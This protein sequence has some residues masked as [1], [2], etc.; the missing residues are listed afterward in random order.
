MNPS[1]LK[2]LAQQ[3]RA[4][5]ASAVTV[6]LLPAAPTVEVT[7]A[8]RRA[9]RQ[10]N[11]GPGRGNRVIFSL[12]DPNGRA[13]RITAPHGPGGDGRRLFTWEKICQVS[14]WAVDK[15]TAAAVADEELQIQALEDLFEWVVRAVHARAP[16]VVDWGDVAIRAATERQFGLELVCTFVF[17]GPL[18]D[19]EPVL[20]TPVGLNPINKVLT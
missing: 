5:F 14:I 17:K 7:V 11:Q 8:Q 3:T 15:S 13:G 20:V 18:Y 16:H 6:G 2:W 19:A 1:G 4:Y 12:G 9:A 10:T